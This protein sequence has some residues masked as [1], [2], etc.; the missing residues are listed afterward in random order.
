MKASTAT[1]RTIAANAARSM[2]EY[3]LG[4]KSNGMR[5]FWRQLSGSV[6]LDHAAFSA[7]GGDFRSRAL[8]TISV[9]GG[10]RPLI[11]VGG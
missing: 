1:L 11:R 8:F 2:V 4:S 10:L 3:R 9:T 6:D 5:H 7:A